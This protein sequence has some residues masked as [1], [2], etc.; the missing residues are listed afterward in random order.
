MHERELLARC[1]A[2]LATVGSKSGSLEMPQ[3]RKKTRG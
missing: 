1:V 2:R 3:Q